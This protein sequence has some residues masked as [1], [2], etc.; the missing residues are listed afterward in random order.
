MMIKKGR[1]AYFNAIPLR[2]FT[3][4]FHIGRIDMKYWSQFAVPKRINCVQNI[5]GKTETTQVNRRCVRQ[6]S[7]M[8]QMNLTKRSARKLMHGDRISFETC[9]RSQSFSIILIFP[10]WLIWLFI[11]LRITPTKCLSFKIQKKEHNL[12]FTF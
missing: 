1:L 8:T 3:L 4:I 6:R 5:N 7:V 11:Q 2:G 12:L 10:S 9:L